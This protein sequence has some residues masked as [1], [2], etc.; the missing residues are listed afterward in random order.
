M[1]RDNTVKSTELPT[2]KVLDEIV[3]FAAPIMATPEEVVMTPP[4]TEPRKRFSDTLDAD[5]TRSY[6]APKKKRTGVCTTK[7]DGEVDIRERFS[8]GHTSVAKV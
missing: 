1:S 2:F 7:D 6:A 8:I 4:L 3:E 5:F